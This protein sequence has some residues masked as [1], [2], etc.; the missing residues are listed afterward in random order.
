VG[1]GG[2][3]VVRELQR[4]CAGNGVGKSARMSHAP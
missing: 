2:A 4:G 1:H 3:G